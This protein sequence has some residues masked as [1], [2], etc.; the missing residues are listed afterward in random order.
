MITGVGGRSLLQGIFPK[1]IEPR[2]PALQADSS[3]PEP[4]GKP[5]AS[6]CS[7]LRDSLPRSFIHQT[8]IEGLLCC[9]GGQGLWMDTE[10]D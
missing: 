8:S 2:S 3:P 6:P 7:V 1:G 4:P 10:V 5:S 9:S